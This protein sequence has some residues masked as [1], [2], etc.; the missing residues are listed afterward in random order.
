MR[1]AHTRAGDPCSILR[2]LAA[3]ILLLVALA[4]F[5]Q[6]P[7]LPYITFLPP[8]QQDSIWDYAST[9]IVPVVYKVNKY[10][11]YA[12]PQLD[13]IARTIEA[14]LAD[15]SL[16]FRYVYVGGS[17]SPEGPV[18]W[19]KDL[20]HYRSTALVRFLRRRT[21]LAAGDI[22]RENLAEDWGST[23]RTLRD[24]S[25][26][27]PAWLDRQ[28]VLDIIASEPD[29]ARRK[30]KIRRIDGSRTWRW[31]VDNWFHAYRNARLVIVCDWQPEAVPA[32]L[33]PAA[34]ETLTMPALDCPQ[35]APPH[36]RPRRM[37]AVKTNLAFA[38][39]A[40]VANIGIEAEL[41][42]G[43]SIELPV[44]Y[45]PYNIS[46]TRRVRLLGIQPELR[47]WAKT[48]GEGWF[49]GIHAT[50]LGFNVSRPGHPRYQDPGHALWGLGLGGG[51]AT[52]LDRK[53]HWA[54]EANIGFGFAKYIYDTYRNDA[55]YRHEPLL[56]SGQKKTWWGP[57]RLGLTIGYQWH[58]RR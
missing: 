52:H 8:L 51:W 46:I 53:K 55:D 50:V 18:W 11:L 34:E 49:A 10:R 20:G 32:A 12:T 7:R 42:P 44:Y 47:R 48:A 29:W 22:R 35:I 39:A 24:K 26:S 45:S 21:S 57:T 33:I 30:D 28:R 13:T 1:H 9:D 56:E 40:L 25:I 2:H 41:W 38:A 23:V 17:A 16:R 37:I 14:V 15:S 6:R 19:N 5:G 58:L 4:C 3:G 31:M 54:F 27:A 43:W 36:F